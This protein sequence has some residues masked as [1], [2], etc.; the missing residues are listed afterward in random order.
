MSKLTKVKHNID[1]RDVDW[2][3]KPLKESRS[4]AEIEAAIA[5]LERELEAAKVAEK[6]ASYNGNIP[7]QVWI[8]SIYLDAA[9]KGSWTSAEWWDGSY[10][11]FVYETEEE[12]VNGAWYHLQELDDEDELDGNDPDNYTIEAFSVSVSE[13]DPDT[14]LASDLEHLLNESLNKEAKTLNE[15]H[16]DPADYWNEPWELEK[17][18]DYVYRQWDIDKADYVSRA[19]AEYKAR[20]QRAASA[21]NIKAVDNNTS[22]SATTEAD[23]TAAKEFW[24][25]AK[26]WKI[27]LEAFHKAFDAELKDLGALGLFNSK[28]ELIGKY[29]Y[30]KIKSLDANSPAVK[31]AKKLWALSYTTPDWP[32]VKY[33]T[34]WITP[35]IY[36]FELSNYDWGERTIGWIVAHSANEAIKKYGE[37]P[38]RL[39]DHGEALPGDAEKIEQLLQEVKV[40]NFKLVDAIGRTT[41]RCIF[42]DYCEAHKIL[43]LDGLIKE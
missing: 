29:C 14:L 25:D 35:H 22:Y 26:N 18:S 31:A 30:G 11:G 17:I 41:K 20:K 3:T 36:E 8:W 2:P 32:K 12:A 38:D 10:D 23:D 42:W 4:V 28:G 39:Y 13:V 9:D 40:Y 1:W 37:K 15:A 24:A 19:W 27:N 6:K 5:V 7:T 21:R 16:V 33:E 34:E 43:S